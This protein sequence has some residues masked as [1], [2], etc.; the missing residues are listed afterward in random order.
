MQFAAERDATAPQA[1]R[2]QKSA[3]TEVLQGICQL[4]VPCIHRVLHADVKL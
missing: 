4:S 3:A 1:S 2:N